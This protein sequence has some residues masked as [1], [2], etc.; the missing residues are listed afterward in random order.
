MSGSKTHAGFTIGTGIEHA[1]TDKAIVRAEYRY[2]DYGSADFS[3]AGLGRNVRIDSSHDL[4]FGV[5]YKF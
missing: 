1:I 4:R 3:S 2:S 5:S